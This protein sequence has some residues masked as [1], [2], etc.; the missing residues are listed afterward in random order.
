MITR[1]LLVD[2]QA[3]ARAYLEHCFDDAE[4]Y[5]IVGSL[6]EASL[7]DLCCEHKKPDV[8][9]LDIQTREK[10]TNGL[11]MA[12]IIKEKF[13]HIKIIMVTGFEEVSWLKRSKDLSLDGFIMKSC[14]KPVYLAALDTV[15]AGGTVFPDEVP[16]IPVNDG[17]QPLTQREIEVLRLICKDYNNKEISGL[18]FISERTVK[19]HIESL[20][21]KTG[22]SS[23]TGLAAYA[24]SGG[25]INPDI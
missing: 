3:S 21:Q 5:E 14:T 12:A 20:M 13:P 4:Q 24:I 18:L 2:D 17:E 9:F 6:S 10:H 7:L 16:K 15:M 1:I 22:K 25:W 19:Y 8:I 23:R 11:D